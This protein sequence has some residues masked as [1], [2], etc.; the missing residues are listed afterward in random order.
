VTTQ[1][2]NLYQSSF[3]NLADGATVYFPS[4]DGIDGD[5]FDTFDFRLKL[6]SGDGDNTLTATVQSDTGAGTF[7]WDETM[8]LRD[9]MTGL[10]GT[11]SWTANAGTTD[12]RAEARNHNAKKWRV[13]IVCS[14]KQAA[15]NNSGI[16][17][18]RRVKV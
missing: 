5:G 14:T 15:A 4:A 8:G 17:T 9:W 1:N 11:V 18:I 6:V 13:K 12:V 2:S 3:A 10:Y 7:E 16:V